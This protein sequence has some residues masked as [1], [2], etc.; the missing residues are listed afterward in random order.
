[1]SLFGIVDAKR[2]VPFAVPVVSTAGSDSV[3][4][5]V[6]TV[7]VAVVVATALFRQTAKHA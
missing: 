7:R 3:F 2:I 1:M 6:S 4:G 5:L